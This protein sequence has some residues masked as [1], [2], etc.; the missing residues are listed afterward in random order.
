MISK[1]I[2][3][4]GRKPCLAV[5]VGT[6][7]SV[8]KLRSFCCHFIVIAFVLCT[9]TAVDSASCKQAYMLCFFLMK[10]CVALNLQFV[11]QNHQHLGCQRTVVFENLS[12]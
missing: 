3:T 11:V 7:E 10:Y 4:G 9:K 12:H 6:V 8:V 1:K 2:G 5:T